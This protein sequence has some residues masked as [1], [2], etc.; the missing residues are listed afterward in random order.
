MIETAHGDIDFRRRTIRREDQLRS[1]L[2]AE[3]AHATGPVNVSR[4]SLDETKI[5]PTKSGP[6]HERSAAAP[7]TINAVAMSDVAGF[8]GHFVAHRAAQAT[9]GEEIFAHEQWQTSETCQGV[10]GLP[11]KTVFLAAQTKHERTRE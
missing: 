5:A 3:R 6:R 10:A 2:R 7:T 4:L 9:A 1:T 8:S 11:V